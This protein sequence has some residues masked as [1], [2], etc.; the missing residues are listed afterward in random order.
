M[1]SS[2]INCIR[3][4]HYSYQL[5]PVDKK[6]IRLISLNTTYDLDSEFKSGPVEC[7]M[8]VF[9]LEDAPPFT[10]LSYM[11]GPPAPTRRIFMNNG[12]LLEIR[13]NLFH[14]LLEF[15][16]MN[17]DDDPQ[18]GA[19]RWFWVDQICIQQSSITE[20]NHQVRMMSHI[21]TSAESVIIWLGNGDERTNCR[22]DSRPL[23][24]VAKEW[25]ETSDP[26]AF[27]VILHASYFT[28]VWIVQEFLLARRVRM[29]LGNMW[30][31]G[32]ERQAKLAV[33]TGNPL[34]EWIP[35]YSFELLLNRAASAKNSGY[36]PLYGLDKFLLDYS[37]NKCENPRDVVYGV[38][39]LVEPEERVQVDYSKLPQQV[40][41]DVGMAFSRMKGES[42]AYNLPMTILSERMGCSW[43]QCRSL[44]KLMDVHSW[45]S[46]ITNMGFELAED[47]GQ[48]VH[49]WFLD[50]QG[51]RYYYDCVED[52]AAERR[53]AAAKQALLDSHRLPD[54][55]EQT[56]KELV[57]SRLSAQ[58]QRSDDSDEDLVTNKIARMTR[59]ITG[60]D[61]EI[62]LKL[63]SVPRSAGLEG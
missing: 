6:Q 24:E 38:L 37:D 5:L 21:Y 14:F 22:W 10:A 26:K 61:A 53:L 17:P 36:V 1:A 43:G 27:A 51:K 45:D 42:H 58:W 54:L 52:P 44:R 32:G 31:D 34:A 23:Y 55:D 47:S 19:D 13:L 35:R 49:R 25:V 40:L 2:I 56:Y 30:L 18:G 9:D 4:D 60:L 12:Q 7:T 62:N 48:E 3:Q 57:D 16:H 63:A 33:A 41:M 28:R 46:P 11:W 29:L 59:L 20:R 8:R 50:S 39:G 15:R